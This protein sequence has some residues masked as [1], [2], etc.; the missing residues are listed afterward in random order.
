MAY[1]SMVSQQEPSGKSCDKEV[2]TTI[3]MSRNSDI[4]SLRFLHRNHDLTGEEQWGRE[5]EKGELDYDLEKND[6]ENT[7]IEYE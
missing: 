2:S 6:V 4:H 5:V 7:R 3:L 1:C